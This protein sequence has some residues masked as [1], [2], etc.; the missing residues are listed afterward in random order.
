CV[1]DP[2]VL[3]PHADLEDIARRLIAD[4][5]HGC[6]PANLADIARISVVVHD[7]VAVLERAVHRITRGAWNVSFLH[8][9]RGC[10]HP[11]QG[12]E[13]RALAAIES[14]ARRAVARM[15]SLL[16]SRAARSSP[17]RAVPSPRSARPRIALRAGAA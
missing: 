14:I 3:D 2:A 13:P 6:R 7:D 1:R 12:K 16:P 11:C 9:P 15:T 17:A 8:H 5:G 10:V 4:L